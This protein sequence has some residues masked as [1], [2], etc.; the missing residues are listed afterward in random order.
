MD[1]SDKIVQR[2]V[3]THVQ[4]AIMSM[5][6]VILDVFQAGRGIIVIKDMTYQ[7]LI[8]LILLFQYNLFHPVSFVFSLYIHLHI[9]KKCNAKQNF[10][11]IYF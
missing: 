5:A 8:N 11:M 1:F 2:N 6:A 9:C 3:I 10:W 7:V 4:A